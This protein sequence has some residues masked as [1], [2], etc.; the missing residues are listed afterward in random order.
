MARIDGVQQA[1]AGEIWAHQP[2]MMFTIGKFDQAVR[3]G[4]SVEERLEMLVELK[5]AQMIGCAF[6]VDLGSQITRRPVRRG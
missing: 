1:D 2:R 6:C 4:R 5:G 3:K